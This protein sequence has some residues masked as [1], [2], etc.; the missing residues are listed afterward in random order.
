MFKYMV[1]KIMLNKKVK[2]HD[3]DQFFLF[4]SLSL[5]LKFFGKMAVEN[6]F[7]LCQRYVMWFL[8][9]S[10]KLTSIIYKDWKI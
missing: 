8:I 6:T 5:K 3:T 9:I 10:K 4:Q 2:Y 1:C 7:K